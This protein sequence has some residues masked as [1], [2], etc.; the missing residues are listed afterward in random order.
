MAESR[1]KKSLLNAKVDAC[2]FALTLAL[3]F[4]SRKIFLDSLGADFIGLTGTLQN[5]LGILNLAEL[6]IGLAVSFSLYKPL[7]QA[8]REQIEEIVSVFGFMYRRVGLVV[9]GAAVVL[10]IFLPLIF[11]ETSFSSGIIYFAYYSFL[12]SSLIS[13]FCNYRSVLLS[14]DQKNY[15]VNVYFQSGNMI[16]TLIQLYIAWKYANYYAWVAIE[17]AYGGICCWMLNRKI[18]QVYPWLNASVLKGAAFRSKYPDIIQ[19]TKQVF[20]HKLKDFLLSQSDQILIYAF[21]SLSMVAYYGNYSLIISRTTSA[22]SLAMNGM[23]AGVG[24]LIAEGNRARILQIFWEL[25]SF[26]YF[27]AGV[28][29]FGIYV[30]IQPFITL[31]LGSKYL[32]PHGILVLLV[33]ITYISVAR[34][35]VDMFNAGYGHFA[36]TWAAWVEGG[37][38]LAVSIIAGYFWGLYGLLLGKLISLLVII[39]FWKP[40]YLFNQGFHAAYWDYWQRALL[41]IAINLV[42]IFLSISLISFPDVQTTLYSGF[43]GWFAVAGGGTL[44]FIAIQAFLMYLLTDSFRSLS[45]RFLKL[46]LFSQT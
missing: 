8:N 18:R 39:V 6:G 11:R 23:G 41:F 20:V 31:W 34:G 33:I 16:K 43:P 42:S 12:I 5:I 35:V 37:L 4:F 30:F 7:Q 3:S 24:N 9:L 17:M 45:S 21:V 10:S 19:K 44:V 15:L 46:K 14:A 25:V 32:L 36:D 1:V 40:F 29:V 2:F 22:L 13:Y 27:I 28:L 38:N 26:R